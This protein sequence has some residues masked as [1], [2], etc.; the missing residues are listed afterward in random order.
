[1]NDLPVMKTLNVQNFATAANPAHTFQMSITKS[2][3]ASVVGINSPSFTV[4]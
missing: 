4:S 3:G 2:I 1:M